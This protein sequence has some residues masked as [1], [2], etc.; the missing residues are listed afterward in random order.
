[1]SDL[2]LT[3]ADNVLK[4]FYLG[5]VRRL[6]NNQTFFWSR[7]DRD[8]STVSADGKSFTVPFNHQRN[9][10]AGIGT[11]ENGTLPSADGQGY[12]SGVVPNKYTY[13]RF[14]VSGPV[15]K[16]TKTSAGAFIKAVRSEIEGL[17]RD[18]KKAMN[19]QVHSDGSWALGFWTSADNTSG[20]VIDDSLGNAFSYLP[21]GKAVTCD[22]IATSDNVT[23][24]GT[25]IVVTQVDEASSPVGYNVTWTGT[26]ASSADN[27][28]LVYANTLGYQIMGLQ[29]II[30]ASDPVI[31]AGGGTKTGLHGLAVASNGFWKA[32][33]VGADST[34]VDLR[35]PLM[36]RVL[37][38]IELNSDYE[39]GDVKMIMGS[40]FMRDKYVELCSNERRA[41][42]TMKLDGGFEAVS[43]NGIPVFGDAESRHNRFYFV[44]PDTLKLFRTSDFDWMDSD[45]PGTILSRVSGKDAYEAVMFHYGDLGCVARNGNGVL[46]GINE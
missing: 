15:I 37:S 11:S 29:G 1:M 14:Q 23:K 28:Y 45:H 24:H 44:V 5:P 40:P 36:Q 18:F 34:L 25:A 41:I 7:L 3:S 38:K 12:T 32:Q 39:A 46:L 30:S 26:V 21:T 2:N 42:N 20:T 8:G 22:L 16:A 10:S 4:V 17:T 33:V 6:L 35:F 9:A 19:Q 27:D 13:G 43:Y 31:P